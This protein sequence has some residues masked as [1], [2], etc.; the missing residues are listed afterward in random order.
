M[1][2]ESEMI[3]NVEP[4]KIKSSEKLYFFDALR[5]IAMLCVIIYH[6]VA[7]YSTVVPYWNLH[8]PATDVSA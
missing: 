6:A 7:S 4:S 5:V 3:K 1:V 8:D 2:N